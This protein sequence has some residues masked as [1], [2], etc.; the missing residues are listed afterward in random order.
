MKILL[1]GCFLI[2][3]KNW[4]IFINSVTLKDIVPLFYTYFNT[5]P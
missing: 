2:K 3:C 1:I 4:L 5:K